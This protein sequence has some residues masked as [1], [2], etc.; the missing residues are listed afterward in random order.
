MTRVCYIDASLRRNLGHFANSCRQICGGLRR[1][2]INVEAFGH[3]TLGKDLA[4]DLKVTPL[5]R[6]DPYV[7]SVPFS[8]GLSYQIARLS[9]LNDLRT[10]WRRGPFEAVYFNSVMSPELAAIGLWLNDFAAGRAPLAVVWLAMPSGTVSSQENEADA[11]LSWH[12]MIDD[13]R[14]PNDP[15]YSYDDYGPG[16]SLSLRD[17]PFDSDPQFVPYFPARHST[18]ESGIRRGCIVLASPDLKD[19]VD[20]LVCLRPIG[21]SHQRG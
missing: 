5:F 14:V 12:I 1:R 13:F 11:S 19:K 3:R 18:E 8:D 16:K 4:N 2:N 21:G 6:N 9:F 10:V 15:G 7:R 17:F 20:L